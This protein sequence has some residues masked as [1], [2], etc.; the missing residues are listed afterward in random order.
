LQNLTSAALFTFQGLIE[1]SQTKY[2]R[3]LSCFDKAL[4]ISPDFLIALQGRALCKS[5]MLQQDSNSDKKD[6]ISDI[7]SDLIK[8]IEFVEELS[9]RLG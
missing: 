9:K 1:I 2:N 5:L 3:A 6:L 7:R 4:N 8:S